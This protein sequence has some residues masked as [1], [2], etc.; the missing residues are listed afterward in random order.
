MQPA[1]FVSVQFFSLTLSL[2]SN[3][4][5]W[6]VPVIQVLTAFPGDTTCL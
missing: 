1:A 4:G 2:E 3:D 5:W 6:T